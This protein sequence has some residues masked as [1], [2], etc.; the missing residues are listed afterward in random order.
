MKTKYSL[1]LS[2]F[3]LGLTLT[4]L[5]LLDSRTSPATAAPA[6][7]PLAPSSTLITVCTS[8]GCDYTTIQAAVDAA[9]YGDE[10]RI[11]AGT[12][13]GASIRP[14]PD[15]Y[16]GPSMVSQLVY[17]SKTV[18]LRGGYTTTN[19]TTPN[20]D[21]NPTILDAQRLGRVIY[22]AGN[23]AP[24]VEGLHITGG[25]AAGLGGDPNAEDS[26]GG[27]YVISA[28]AIISGNQVFD[29]TAGD[30]DSWGGGILLYKSAAI[31]HGNTVFSNTA[32][33]GGGGIELDWSDATVRGNTVFS[34]TA[35]G[36][37]G[38][39]V[40]ISDNAN[41]SENTA[42]ANTAVNG[43]GVL[44]DNS[45]ATLD[46]NTVA[47][48]TADYGGGGLILYSSAAK[49]NE[50]V[51]QNNAAAVLGGGLYLLYESPAT[52]VNNV[53][54]Q[55]QAN[56]MGSG[57]F[58]YDSSPYLLHNTIHSNSGGDGSG[59]HVDGG[60]SVT[61]INTVLV[62]QT[63]GIA[64]AGGSGATLDGVLW[65]GNGANTGGAG[66]IAVTR[67]VTGTPRFAADG[68]HLTA[69]SAAV[70]AGVDTWVND[71]ID[72][73]ERLYS[74][75]DLGVDELGVQRTIDPAEGGTLV[76]MDTQGLT[77]TIE[78]PPGTV[79]RT[80][81]LVYMPLV[82]P[83]YPL[84][85]GMV[86]AGHAFDLDIFCIW[87]VYLPLIMRN[88]SL[89][90]MASSADSPAQGDSAVERPTLSNLHTAAATSSF[91]SCSLSLLK[92]ITIT[93]YYS[94]QDVQAIDEDTLRLD[95][96]TGTY[97][98]DNANT[99]IPPSTYITDTI[100]N[101]LQVPICHLSRHSMRGR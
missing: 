55:N 30:T 17:I 16:A 18:T 14:A 84:S 3:A 65:Y 82:S 25:D 44:F 22:I 76:Y 96:W 79:T 32:S 59:V 20:P 43:G 66:T 83:T 95:R 54:I 73:Q 89:G 72:G 56:S 60:S 81:T 99:C 78:I 46:R 50:N 88:S 77:T 28:T 87:R 91:T 15:G 31:L 68:Y 8:G 39:Y 23:I 100:A 94:D 5:C 9:S 41:L 80:A 6:C 85:P 2:A 75:P 101:M 38:L 27:V 45:A 86:F 24:T 93:I 11:A 69:G 70:D 58:I 4:L 90:A 1:I 98:E 12:Y 29:N 13:T 63:V 52:L 64:V 19:W 57:L 37:G 26:G 53:V 49:L 36:G 74:T 92:P 7:R 51:I 42:F 61:L 40:W 67:D 97:W 62:S 35:G 47:S 71:D 10:I 34:N 33:A 21:A 48:N